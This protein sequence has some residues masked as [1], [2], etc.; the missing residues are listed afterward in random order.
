MNLNLHSRRMQVLPALI[1]SFFGLAPAIAGQSGIGLKIVV[2]ENGGARV[3]VSQPAPGPLKLRI[4]DASNRAVPGAT[5]LFTSPATGPSGSFLN[6][7][8]SMI[9]FTNQQGLAETQGYQGNSIAG[10]YQ[11]QVQVS[12][13]GE[14]ATLSVDHTNVAARKS[15]GKMFLI[16]AAAG[17]AAA[18]VFAVKGAH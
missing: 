11:I 18:S 3:V 12:Y 4:V 6:G 1:L 14:V 9:V 10:G 15:S 5:V 13:M 17:A 7:S 16:G 2:L 8:N